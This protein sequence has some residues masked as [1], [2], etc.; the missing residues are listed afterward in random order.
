MSKKGLS[1]DQ[2]KEVLL[3][4]ML[5]SGTIH[6]M[7]EV[8]SL[9][10]RNKII[11]QAIKEVV[12]ALLAERTISMEKV[13]T[14]NIYW[15]FPSQRK[16]GLLAQRDTLIS[17]LSEAKAKL[18]AARARKSDCMRAVQ[19]SDKERLAIQN[20]TKAALASLESAKGELA[21]LQKNDPANIAAKMKELT[22]SKQY[23]DLW[24]E[25]IFIIRQRM[26]E[27]FGFPAENVD[28]QFGIPA[29]FEFV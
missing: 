18:E 24:T 10:K 26:I 7:Q 25:N 2:K 11:P 20:E 21:K 16:A 22:Q 15:A 1:F 9:G 19:L 14:Q 3:T 8:E 28:A 12:E 5:S 27:K 23:C 13:G 17:Q 29:D 6:N 4:A